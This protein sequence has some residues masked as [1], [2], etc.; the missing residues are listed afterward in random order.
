MQAKLIEAQKG[1]LSCKNQEKDFS[2]GDKTTKDGG[3]D[4]LTKDFKKALLY[5]DSSS[6]SDQNLQ[7]RNDLH[8]TDVNQNNTKNEF[9]SQESNNMKI[10]DESTNS[11]QKLLDNQK[12]S[13]QVI[14]KPEVNISIP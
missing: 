3:F 14:L 11:Q 7:K 6:S 1:D 4:Q 2:G 10:L 9:S 5:E 8:I 12:D 13:S